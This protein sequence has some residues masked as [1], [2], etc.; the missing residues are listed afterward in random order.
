MNV[1]PQMTKVEAGGSYAKAEMNDRTPLYV[2]VL[3][4]GVAML[5]IGLAL[6]ALDKAK[7]AETQLLLLREDMRQMA[8]D[9]AKEGK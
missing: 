1:E 8:I 9:Q 6:W 3:A 5:S 2:A 7:D 4:W